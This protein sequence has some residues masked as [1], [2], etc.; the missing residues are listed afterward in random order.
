M[1]YPAVTPP[2]KAS[3]NLRA[4]IL[5]NGLCRVYDYGPKWDALFDHAGKCQGGYDHPSYRAAALDAFARAG[6]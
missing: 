4:E 5:P 1:S 3:R 2:P 6:R